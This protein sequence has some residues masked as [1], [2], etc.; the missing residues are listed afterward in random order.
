VYDLIDSGEEIPTYLLK[1]AFSADPA[2]I[3]VAIA[4]NPESS[5]LADDLAK[6]ELKE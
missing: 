1:H 4:K 6:L 5:S 2:E 3:P